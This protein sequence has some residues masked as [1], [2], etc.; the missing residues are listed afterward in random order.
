MLT[1]KVWSLLLVLAIIFTSWIPQSVGASD[2]ASAPQAVQGSAIVQSYPMPSIYTA[3]QVYSLKAGS[4]AVPVIEYLPEYDY[5]E[6]SFSGT[7][8]IEVTADEPITSYSISP[9]A[10]N[11]QGTVDGNKLTFTL[12]S[13]TYVIVD[14]NEVPG[15]KG[16]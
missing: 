8:S 5:A 15:G 2:S 7:V 4:E 12:S 3:S 13:S 1:R 10:K 16:G 9:L 11:I 6:F 14:I